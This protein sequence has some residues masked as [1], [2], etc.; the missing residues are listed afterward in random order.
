V[1]EA[2]GGELERV[3][4]RRIDPLD[5][6]EGKDDGRLSRERTY[7]IQEG[8]RNSMLVG[9]RAAGFL[10]QQRHLE[11][12]ALRGRKLEK[13]V[14]G[15]PKQ[16]CQRRKGK[17]RFGTGGFRFK[18]SKSPRPGIL[19]R[20]LPERRLADARLTLEQQSGA[21]PPR[22]REEVAN[23]VEFVLPA[24]DVLRRDHVV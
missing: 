17:L 19:E 2:T 16:V 24:D 14:C 5:V 20:R 6:I 10:E 13:N 11:R 15:G 7:R 1:L 23:R 9:R 18:D 3:G 12:P 22:S 4:R 21:M 8:E